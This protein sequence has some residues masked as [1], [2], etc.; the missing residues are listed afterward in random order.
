M[1]CLGYTIAWGF[2]GAFIL[3]A[4]AML[5]LAPFQSSESELGKTIFS[6]RSHE[7]G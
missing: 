6:F 4:A 7:R 5:A 2:Y 1:R 3:D